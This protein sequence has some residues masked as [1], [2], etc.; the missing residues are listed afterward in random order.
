MSS[1]VLWLIIALLVFVWDACQDQYV[2][3]W[4]DKKK[5]NKTEVFSIH[6]TVIGAIGLFKRMYFGVK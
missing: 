2:V 1:N 3:L 4:R 5:D 6:I